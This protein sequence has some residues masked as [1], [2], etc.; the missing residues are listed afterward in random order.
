MKEGAEAPANY[1]PGLH[2]ERKRYP[3][4]TLE[5]E[6]IWENRD[7]QAPFNFEVGKPSP[8]GL[9]FDLSERG[10]EHEVGLSLATRRVSHKRSA[11]I[12]PVFFKDK[13]G[14]LYRDIDIKGAGLVSESGAPTSWY[15]QTTSESL[16][17]MKLSEPRMKGLMDKEDALHDS[18]MAERLAALGIRTHR[19][20]AVIE[21]RELATLSATNEMRRESIEALRERGELPETFVP[22][23][24]IRAFGTKT[25]IWD[26]GDYISKIARKEVNDAI[27][28]VRREADPQVKDVESYLDWFAKTLGLNVGRMHANGYTHD[29]LTIHNITIDCR[30]TD[31][32][33]VKKRSDGDTDP[34]IPE[35]ESAEEEINA[36]PPPSEFWDR[37]SIDFHAAIKSMENYISRLKKVFPELRDMD[38]EKL[39]V[40]FEK[41]YFEE[42]P[43]GNT[44]LRWF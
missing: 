9:T 22:V 16:F 24:Q 35:Y 23:V 39:L 44:H 42:N 29:F 10:S 1:P 27:A 21:L 41:A 11:D 2:K 28:L 3:T 36:A 20:I 32:D 4:I 14:V 15:K 19:S 37:A 26:V 8:L 13:A 12:G 18:K 33:D 5:N 34:V 40:A 25:R 38:H 30:L 43:A 31:F 17:P 7:L 6:V